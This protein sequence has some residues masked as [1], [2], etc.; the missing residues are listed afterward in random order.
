MQVLACFFRPVDV[1]FPHKSFLSATFVCFSTGVGRTFLFEN[2]IIHNV[3]RKENTPQEYGVW[4]PAGEQKED[5][6]NKVSEFFKNCWSNYVDF[7]GKYGEY[8]NRF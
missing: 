1:L 3:K 6:M 7:M 2:D 4:L 5:I 8:T